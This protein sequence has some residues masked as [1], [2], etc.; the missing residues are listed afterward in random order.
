M[1][2]AQSCWVVWDNFYTGDKQCKHQATHE[3]TC[4]NKI[5]KMPTKLKK[6]SIP[7]I[8]SAFLVLFGGAHRC[9]SLAMMSFT[10]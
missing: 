6:G 4:H 10:A 7:A 3:K 5:C 1:V 2:P 8:L 9:T